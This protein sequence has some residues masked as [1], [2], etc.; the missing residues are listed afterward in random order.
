MG[1]IILRRRMLRWRRGATVWNLAFVRQVEFWV[2]SHVCSWF[3]LG[4]GRRWGG[5]SFLACNF[6]LRSIYMYL[7]IVL[8]CCEFEP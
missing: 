3:S 5:V 7:E 2:A 4:V 8:C 1:G 6:S